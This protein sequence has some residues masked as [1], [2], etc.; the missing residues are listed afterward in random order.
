MMQVSLYGIEV[1]NKDSREISKVWHNTQNQ[2][3]LIWT[4]FCK[5]FKLLYSYFLKNII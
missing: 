2:R 1:E 4:K 3:V 5:K